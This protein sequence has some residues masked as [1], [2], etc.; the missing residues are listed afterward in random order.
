MAS[1][2]C[3]KSNNGRRVTERYD[4]KPASLD[5]GI[6]QDL[7]VRLGGYTGSRA[8]RTIDHRL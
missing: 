8:I 1:N 2:P 4:L 3:L 6:V 5:G 7:E